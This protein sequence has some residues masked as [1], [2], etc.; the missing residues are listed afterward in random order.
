MKH[1]YELPIWI[2]A[3][4]I[5]GAVKLIREYQRKA[6]EK[7]RPVPTTRTEH[8]EKKESWLDKA[9][10]NAHGLYVAGGAVI[11]GIGY[12]YT[13]WKSAP[14]DSPQ[15]AFWGMV[16][17][18][19]GAAIAGAVIMAVDWRLNGTHQPLRQTEGIRSS[20]GWVMRKLRA[21]YQNGDREIKISFKKQKPN[22]TK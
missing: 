22:Q 14:K 5:V 18:L 15:K 3:V 13:A 4:L 8:D 2:V 9:L 6:R 11:G 12:A 19:I 17:A 1:D 10:H 21:L 16:L 20:D 7:Y